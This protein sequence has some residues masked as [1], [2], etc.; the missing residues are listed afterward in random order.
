MFEVPGKFKGHGN[1]FVSGGKDGLICVWNLDHVQE[2]LSPIES[3]KV[4]DPVRCVVTGG[5]SDGFIAGTLMNDIFHIYNNKEMIQKVEPIV[6]GHTG[7]VCALDINESIVASGCTDGKLV[8]R[9][10]RTGE[11]IWS[12]KLAEG[13]KSLAIVPVISNIL[14]GTAGGKI[15]CFSRE[16]DELF[17]NKQANDELT[18]LKIDSSGSLLAAGSRDQCI[19]LF[20]YHESKLM[21]FGVLKGH[22]STVLHID[23]TLSGS[24]VLQTFNNL[25]TV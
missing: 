4:N 11:H 10:P 5:E 2:N 8:V 23:W 16:G 6:V 19:Y 13:V 9:D 20:S 18:S 22:S 21:K 15:V 3:V 7:E 25:E 12:V 24:K 17:T 1:T 14:V